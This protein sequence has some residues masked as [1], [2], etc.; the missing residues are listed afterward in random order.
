MRKAFNNHPQ[1]LFFIL[2]AYSVR[3]IPVRQTP[4]FQ[5]K[6][7]FKNRV[8]NPPLWIYNPSKSRIYNRIYQSVKGRI[9]KYILKVANKSTRCHFYIL[10]TVYF[11]PAFQSVKGRIYNYL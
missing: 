2:S 9:Y 8:Y 1:A 7:G 5:S 4:D 6:A 3:Q 10:K 11:E